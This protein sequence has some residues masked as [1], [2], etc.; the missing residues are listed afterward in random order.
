MSVEV[1]K[2][3]DGKVAGIREFGAFVQLPD[4]K[5]GL[6][7]ISEVAEEYIKDIKTYLNENQEVKVKILSVGENGKISLSIRKAIDKPVAEVTFR[8]PE[9]HT[10]NR[11]QSFNNIN[12]SNSGGIPNFEDMISKFMKDSDER[13]H[14]LKRNVESKRG[15]ARR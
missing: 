3:V 8:K 11:R 15:S 14:V 9:R 10:E 1:G 13:M 7:H 4:G 6:V 12:N 2:V 5:T